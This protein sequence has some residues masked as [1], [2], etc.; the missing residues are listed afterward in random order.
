MEDLSP[1]DCDDPTVREAHVELFKLFLIEDA[2]STA[3]DGPMEIYHRFYDWAKEHGYDFPPM[4]LGDDTIRGLKC[5]D[6]DVAE[7]V[8]EWIED[9][10]VQ[11]SPRVDVLVNRM[12]LTKS[13][14]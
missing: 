11:L 13:D 4:A 3:R 10:N 1:P 5:M 12:L 7:A 8:L 9:G 6:R 14:H 2:P